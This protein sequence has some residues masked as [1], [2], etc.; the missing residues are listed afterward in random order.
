MGDLKFLEWQRPFREALTETTPQKLVE[1]V[2]LAEV[3]ILSRMT[4]ITITPKTS[5]EAEA[6]VDAFGALAVLRKKTVNSKKP[7]RPVSNPPMTYSI[8]E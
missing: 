7:H 8:N 1:R 4:E 6:L 5:V 3:A 2:G